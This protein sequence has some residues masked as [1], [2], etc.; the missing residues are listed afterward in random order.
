MNNDWSRRHVMAGLAGATLAAGAAR[1]QAPQP[2]RVWPP[3]GVKSL[4]P[5][6]DALVD[7]NAKTEQLMTGFGLSEGPLWVGGKDGYL[8]VCDVNGN[9][10]RRWSQKDGES[11]WL[12][13]S[14]YAGPPT[15]IMRQYGVGGLI[16]ARGGIVAA[17]VGNR[18]IA[19]INPKT[20]TKIMLATHFEGKR[21]QSPNDLVQGRDGSIYFTDP[22]NGLNG[23]LNSVYKELP[24][25]AIFRLTPDN[26]V[27]LF[28]S[29]LVNPNGIGL[30]PDGRT[31]YVTHDN[32]YWSAFDVGP[33]GKASNK[34]FFV[35]EK[36]LG[37][38]G[39]DGLKIDTQSNLWTTSSQ[40]VSVFDK[41]GKPLGIV[42]AGPGRHSNVELGADGYLYIAYGD[43]VARVPV[44]AR[45]VR[46][47]K[48]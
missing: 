41:T 25:T 36:A 40:G 4:D 5:A 17:D 16:L 42:N 48:A 33:D 28:D 46:L 29:S 47:G 39:G 10:V 3:A 44:R 6:F 30:S 31:L 21:L 43:K 34:R 37:I 19:A 38:A 14:G 27:E 32:K 18:G 1:A 7:A 20:K 12:K 11:E 45:P 8:L 2:G 23:G 22:T 26:R 15:K 24:Y 13:P 9:V 35:D